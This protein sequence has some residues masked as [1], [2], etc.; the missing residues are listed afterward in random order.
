VEPA[1]QQRF[2]IL[3]GAMRAVYLAAVAFSITSTVVLIAR[4]GRTMV[5]P[6][7]MRT[8]TDRPPSG[9]PG[10]RAGSPRRRD[11]RVTGVEACWGRV[12]GKP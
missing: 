6:L 12:L 7:S 5:L 8:G 10:P 11:E 3:D 1:F 9:Q 2:V 4:S